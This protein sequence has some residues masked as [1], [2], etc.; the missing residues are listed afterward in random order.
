MKYAGRRQNDFTAWGQ[1][2][3]LVEQILPRADG[4]DS[5]GPQ[6]HSCALGLSI[7]H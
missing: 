3:A 5:H 6:S 7:F 4:R 2:S 1:V